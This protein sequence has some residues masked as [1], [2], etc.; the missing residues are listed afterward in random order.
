ML[1][2]LALAL[3]QRNREALAGEVIRHALALPERDGAFPNLSLWA[4]LEQA[5]IG[6]TR[7]AEEHLS[8]TPLKALAAEEQLIVHFLQAVLAVQKA[9]VPD[10]AKALADACA[11]LRAAFRDNTLPLPMKTLARTYRRCMRRMSEDAS[12]R[13]PGFWAWWECVRTFWRS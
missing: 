12:R 10:R 6:N 4:S 3:R 1:H 13:Y 11:G 9:P 5:L 8:G 7:A 2:S